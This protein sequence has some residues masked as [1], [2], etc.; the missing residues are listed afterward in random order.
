M[1]SA[2]N[3]AIKQKQKKAS[4]A[5]ASSSI[6]TG[7]NEQKTRG[8]SEA[9]DLRRNEVFLYQLI[10]K[11]ILQIFKSTK[12]I[13]INETKRGLKASVKSVSPPTASSGID[14]VKNGR[15]GRG[16]CVGGSSS[17][18]STDARN[19]SPISMVLF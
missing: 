10:Y 1:G 7:W 17:Q 2:E 4:S 16:G 3:L 15:T 13:V 14:D 11:I 5:G 6:K 12:A 9:R 19:T 8:G 18:C